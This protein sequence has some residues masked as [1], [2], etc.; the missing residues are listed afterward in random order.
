MR[1]GDGQRRGVARAWHDGERTGYAPRRDRILPHGPRPLLRRARE[2][3][4]IPSCRAPSR[5]PCQWRRRRNR[6]FQLGRH[7]CT[8]S[9]HLMDHSRPQPTQADHGHRPMWLDK[10][11]KPHP[12]PTKRSHL[13][14]ATSATR[15]SGSIAWQASEVSGADSFGFEALAVPSPPAASILSPQTQK[16]QTRG[17]AQQLGHRSLSA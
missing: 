15:E 6:T 11:A 5:K 12:W 1:T 10:S 17:R 8:D 14:F 2:I 16:Y 13:V 3:F 9:N 7:V 4:T